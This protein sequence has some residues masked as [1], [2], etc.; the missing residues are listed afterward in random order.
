MILST[1]GSPAAVIAADHGSNPPKTKDNLIV[2]GMIWYEEQA[3]G[4]M[5]EFRLRSVCMLTNRIQ[6]VHTSS[7]VASIHSHRAAIHT[8]TPKLV[9]VSRHV[10][11]MLAE[12]SGTAFLLTDV[13]TCV[14]LGLNLYN[15][16]PPPSQ[17]LHKRSIVLVRELLVIG[18]DFG[19]RNFISIDLEWGDSSQETTLNCHYGVKKTRHR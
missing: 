11:I 16:P 19:L 3:P 1:L 6:I 15:L 14:D 13:A 2:F 8:L 17:L 10:K 7:Q 18:N 12:F 5:D 4:H 9:C